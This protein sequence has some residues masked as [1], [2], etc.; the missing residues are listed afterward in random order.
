MDKFYQMIVPSINL[1][2]IDE[3]VKNIIFPIDNFFEKFNKD[4]TCHRLNAENINLKFLTFDRNKIYNL[5][6]WFYELQKCVVFKCVHPFPTPF[7]ENQ[8]YVELICILLCIVDR[9]LS[10]SQLI[11]NIYFRNDLYDKYSPFLT[12]YHKNKLIE[13]LK[14]TN[15]SNEDFERDMFTKENFCFKELANPFKSAYL[16]P[17]QNI[18]C[19]DI[20]LKG[21]KSLYKTDY[22]KTI[23]YLYK[24][25]GKKNFKCFNNYRE[26]DFVIAFSSKDLCELYVLKFNMIKFFEANDDS[27]INWL[28]D[29]ISL[30]SI[31]RN[32]FAKTFPIYSKIGMQDLMLLIEAWLYLKSS[33]K[34]C[35]RKYDK[36]GQITLNL[37][38][39]KPIEWPYNSLIFTFYY[40]T[41]LFVFYFVPK[42]NSDKKKFSHSW[43][44]LLKNNLIHLFI[45]EKSFINLF[46]FPS[47]F[48][49]K[50]N[51]INCL[52][53]QNLTA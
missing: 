36:L 17:I 20:Y 49:I 43:N 7:F 39:G 29:G 3:N 52:D 27:L 28:N 41:Y 5:D 16:I 19:C 21:A 32:N 9:F 51:P 45:Y 11:L 46:K 34:T 40:F 42:S 47:K 37:S 15:F 12:C 10:N 8:I 24:E 1:K 31:R 22:L 25:K 35:I 50:T 18:N 38:F 26:P 13:I 14:L 53:F 6:K 23:A 4:K 33:Y 30:E 2:S 44:N 48:K